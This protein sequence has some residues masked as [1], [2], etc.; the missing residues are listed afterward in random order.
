MNEKTKE[1]ENQ[2]INLAVKDILI[3]LLDQVVEGFNIF[4]SYHYYCDYIGDYRK[5][6]KN[7]HYRLSKQIS[8]LKHL[9]LIEKYQD[10]KD[11]II[12]LTPIGREKA[13]QY[14]FKDINPNI[15]EQW[16]KK[17]RMVIFD[18]PEEKKSIRDTIRQKLKQMGLFQL[19]KSVFVYPFECKEL[20]ISLKYGYCVGKNLQYIIA[21]SIE[22]EIDLVD[23]F[24]K[25]G[26]L[27]NSHLN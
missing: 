1:M 9:K 19:Q 14:L 21:D 27:K 3:S 18:I 4:D 5:W 23:Y 8:R 17:W 13:F 24:I 15:P 6:S 2:E 16:D 25:Q 7:H 26:I 11:T 12:E 10:G 22:G 20:I